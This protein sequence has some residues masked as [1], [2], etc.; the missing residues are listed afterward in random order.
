MGKPPYIVPTKRF[1]VAGIPKMKETKKFDFKM[2]HE[3]HYH[4][5]P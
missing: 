3:I 5:F 4:N 2:M 1:A